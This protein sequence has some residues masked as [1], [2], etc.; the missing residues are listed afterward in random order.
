MC[1]NVCFVHPMAP[2]I[3]N[4]Y[5]CLWVLWLPEPARCHFEDVIRLFINVVTVLLHCVCVWYPLCVCVCFSLYFHVKQIPLPL[6]MSANRV[7]RI[8]G[9]DNCCGDSSQQLLW[10]MIPGQHRRSADSSFTQRWEDIALLFHR[11]TW[12]DSPCSPAQHISWRSL[13]K[14]R[15][16]VELLLLGLFY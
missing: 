11:Q 9:L 16:A 4:P 7:T 12:R 2:I 13:K 15:I 14:E 5:Y 3:W 10:W 6:L 1:V 8:G